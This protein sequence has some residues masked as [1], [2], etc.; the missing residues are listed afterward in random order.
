MMSMFKYVIVIVGDGDEK[1]NKIN[2]MYIVIYNDGSYMCANRS[3][4]S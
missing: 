3:C 4:R 1:N 2:N